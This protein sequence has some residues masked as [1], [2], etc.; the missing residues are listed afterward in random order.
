MAPAAVAGRGIVARDGDYGG[1]VVSV[2]GSR[3]RR[4]Q[5]ATAPR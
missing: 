1:A 2:Q 5:R 3:P 4:Q